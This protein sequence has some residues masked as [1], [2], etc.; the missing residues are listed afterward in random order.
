M[1]VIKSSIVKGIKKVVGGKTVKVASQAGKEALES[2]VKAGIKNTATNTANNVVKT[3]VGK[4]AQYQADAQK[5]ID[6]GIKDG[7]EE[8]MKERLGTLTVT[9]L[10]KSATGYKELQ[11]K[12]KFIRQLPKIYKEI[13]A[14]EKKLYLKQAI[15]MIEK[16]H[17]DAV[18]KYGEDAVNRISRDKDYKRS[19]VF[20][21]PSTRMRTK[22]LKAIRD[23]LKR[24]TLC[25]MIEEKTTAEIDEFVEKYFKELRLNGDDRGKMEILKDKLEGNMADFRDFVDYVTSPSF[26]KR[27]DSDSAKYRD[28]D[29]YVEEMRDR[30]DR[31][32][33]LTD[34]KAYK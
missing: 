21:E 8:Y 4:I 23:E 24:G 27:Y 17:K 26:N 28:V 29:S 14:Y 11:K 6:K 34:T 1:A 16:Q 5:L 9:E 15:K 10:V 32:I 22:T 13:D 3:K 33:D 31:M 19:A 30:L 18:A 12:M 20:K 7:L 25:D 2:G